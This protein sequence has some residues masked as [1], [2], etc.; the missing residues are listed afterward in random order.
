MKDNL[1]CASGLPVLSAAHASHHYYCTT[2]TAT[3]VNI[4][5]RNTMSFACR[6]PCRLAAPAF[7]RGLAL[8]PA[9]G[10]GKIKV[11]VIAG[12]TGS[13]KTDLSMRLA[14]SLNAEIV[15]AD[16]AQLYVGL[17]IGTDKVS[18]ADRAQV[19]H[20]M[21]D[22]LPSTASSFSAFSFGALATRAI[23][24]RLFFPDS[25]RHDSALVANS[26]TYDCESLQN[27]AL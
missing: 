3:S 20:H 5:A 18:Q 19:P 7:R 15:S 25:Y 16:S 23:R 1:V 8:A 24:V 4:P 12:P 6:M 21:V 22:I 13:G 27:T 17:D 11:L 14:R 26:L 10:A 9:A 2:H